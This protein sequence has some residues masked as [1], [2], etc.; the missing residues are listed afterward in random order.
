MP[1]DEYVDA[2]IDEAEI[3]KYREMYPDLG[4]SETN[5]KQER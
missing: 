1:C 5:E 3:G 2:K 4:I